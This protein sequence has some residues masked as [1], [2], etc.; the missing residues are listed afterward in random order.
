MK[1]IEVE[2]FDDLDDNVLV[3]FKMRMQ[4]VRL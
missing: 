4:E 2:V 1:M 3:G